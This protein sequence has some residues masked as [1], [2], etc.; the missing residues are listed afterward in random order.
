LNRNDISVMQSRHY[1][2][3]LVMVQGNIS[4]HSCAVGCSL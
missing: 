1:R 2:S 4:T 3:W